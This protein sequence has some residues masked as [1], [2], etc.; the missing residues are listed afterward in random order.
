VLYFENLSGQKEDEYFRDG[1]TED[2]ITELL[3]VKNLK[4][5]PR[6]AVLAFRDKP[7]TAPEVGQQLN[8]NYVLSGSLRRAGNRLRVTAQ[9]VETR[10]GHGV[11]AERFD[12]TLEDVFEVQDEIA[13]S[14]T[15]ALRITLTPQEERAIARKPTDNAEAYD[16][17]LRGRSYSLRLTR[18]DLEFAMQ[19]YEQAIA[20]DPGFALAYAETAIACAEIYWIHE[21]DEKWLDRGRKACERALELD[22]QL[23]EGY[24]ARARIL[25]GEKKFDEAVRSARRA[26]ELNPNVGAAYYALGRSLFLSDRLEEA[27]DIA[28]RAIEVGGDN[29]NVFVPFIMSLERLGRNE[30]AMQLRE[31]RMRALER[32]LEMVPEDTRARILLST[33]YAHFGKVDAAVREAQRALALRPNDTNILYNAACTYAVVCKKNDALALLKRLKEMHFPE[34]EW[35]ARDPDLASLRDEPEFLALIGKE[36]NP[37]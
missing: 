34:F 6:A 29:Y 25:E 12:R 31:G 9:L 33:N 32:Q 26:L 1:M 23:A 2:V 36:K 15:Q 30:S 27:A 19:M 8:A 18:A 37:A 13:R 22:P 11:W 16:C 3:K 5:F 20:L 21:P 10:T 17:F 14:I 4:V 24:A 7:V 35:A 28:G